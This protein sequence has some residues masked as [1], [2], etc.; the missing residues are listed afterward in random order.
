MTELLVGTKKGLFVL[1]GDP[2]SEKPFE[3]KARAFP[4]NVVEFAIRDPR[5]GRYFASVTSGHYGPARDAHDRP[6]GRVGADDG[7]RLPRGRRL[8][9]RADLDDRARRGRRADVR[10]RRARG[11]VLLDRRRDDVGA[12]PRALRPA[13]PEGLAAGR[14][15]TLPPLDRHVA[16]GPEEARDRDLGGR[17]S[18]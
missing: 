13:H 2:G 6:D 14:R 4:G 3:V 9:A 1:E 8:D 12:E 5:S 11:S 17:A 18:G 10:G 7:P 15:R 16:G